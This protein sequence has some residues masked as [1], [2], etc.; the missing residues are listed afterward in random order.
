MAH[1]A[2]PTLQSHRSIIVGSPV[3]SSGLLH[4]T[5]AAEELGTKYPSA[6]PLIAD[7][8]TGFGSGLEGF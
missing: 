8:V 1:L 3:S 2:A 4:V 6:S 7:S 5:R